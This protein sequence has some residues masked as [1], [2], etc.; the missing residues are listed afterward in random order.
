MTEPVVSPQFAELVRTKLAEGDLAWVRDHFQSGR[1]NFLRDHISAEERGQFATRLTSGDTAW[2]REVIARVNI[3]GIGS[4][5]AMPSP[6]DTPV[7]LSPAT[8]PPAGAQQGELYTPRRL[9]PPPTTPSLSAPGSGPVPDVIHDHAAFAPVRPVEPTPSPIQTTAL[10]STPE[11]AVVAPRLSEPLTAEEEAALVKTDTPRGRGGWWKILLP[12]V[13]VAGGLFWLVNHKKSD[14]TTATVVTTT[15]VATATTASGTLPPTA[16]TITALDA[17]GQDGNHKT[18]LAAIDKAGLTDTLQKGGPYTL[19]QL[20]AN[21]DALTKVLLYHVTQGSLIG[22]AMKPGSLPSLEGQPLAIKVEGTNVMVND[23]AA[24]LGGGTSYSI[25]R[26]LVPADVD[27]NALAGAPV[28]PAVTVAPP[29]EA[30]TAPA[31]DTTV[32]APAPTEAPTTA[33]P[34]PAPGTTV[35]PAPAPAG[36]VVSV[37]Y[38]QNSSNLTQEATITLR[39]LAKKIRTSGPKTVVT[40]TGY[41]D[42]N[43]EARVA[44]A[45]SRERAQRVVDYLVSLGAPAN[46][47]VVSGG[48][49]TNAD[50]GQNRR[51][52]I[53]LS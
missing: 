17:L 21:K 28:A 20:L 26:V 23:V 24:T 30:T 10:T 43:A 19:D 49:V 5:G 45:A 9:E 35:A 38:N 36:D 25:D 44:N 3:P 14:P 48:G 33:A 1:L 29:T 8:E 16:A 27:L 42:A 15:E 12:L 53:A 51:A 22:G 46:Y 50:A 39:D 11:P 31:P 40:V 37:F 47:K 52:D 2:V 6:L 34:A 13:L 18:L 4:L 32:P 41:A 7:V